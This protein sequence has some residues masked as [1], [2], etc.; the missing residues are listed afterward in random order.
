MRRD[1]RV[2]DPGFRAAAMR[3]RPS[4]TTPAGSHRSRTA[5][6]GSAPS[7]S[8]SPTRRSRPT[9]RGS[10]SGTTAWAR[11]PTTSSRPTRPSGSCT[12]GTSCA[13]SSPRSSGSTTIYPVRRPAR[14]AQSR[15][16][17]RRRRAAVALRPDRLRRVARAAG[18]R[19]GWRLRGRAVHPHRRRRALRRRRAGARGRPRTAHRAADDAG[20][21]ARVR[22]PPLD[23]PGLADPRRDAAAR[24]AVRLRHQAGHDEQRAAEGRALRAGDRPEWETLLDRRG[25]R[26]RGRERRARQHDARREERPGRRGV[27]DGARDAARRTRGVRRG[28]GARTSR[29]SR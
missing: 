2:R 4:S 25:L 29:S 3:W 16:D 13:R 17:G 1:R 28:R 19:R 14:R 21:A 6:A 27:G 8:A 15:G 11:L 23:A 9:I 24:R 18:C 10:G 20:D 7:I 26:R 12:S 22:G 5:A